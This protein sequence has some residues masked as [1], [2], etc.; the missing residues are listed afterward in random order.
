MIST[1]KQNKDIMEKVYVVIEDWNMDGERG[2]DIWVYAT[3][4]K[5][6]ER[7]STGIFRLKKDWEVDENPEDWEV[8]T[9]SENLYS[10][11][12]PGKDYQ[13]TIECL[14]KDVEG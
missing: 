1:I 14:T 13:Y 7:M 2:S 12:N 10:I 8:M 5:A 3:K 11:Y 9:D 4:E 6:L